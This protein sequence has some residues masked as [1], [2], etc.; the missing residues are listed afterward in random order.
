MLLFVIEV[1]LIERHDFEAI[2]IFFDGRSESRPRAPAALRSRNMASPLNDGRDAFAPQDGLIRELGSAQRLDQ[3]GLFLLG[4]DGGQDLLQ[5][6][7]LLGRFRRRSGFLFGVAQFR[8]Q[9][10][11]CK[12]GERHQKEI[13]KAARE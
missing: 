5:Q 3:L 7:F 12:N 9:L 8:N 1:A 10:N 6:H 13:R 11:Y 2:A 4:F